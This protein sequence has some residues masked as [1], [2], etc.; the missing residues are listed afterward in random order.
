MEGSTEQAIVPSSHQTNPLPEL[1]SHFSTVL[2]DLSQQVKG[3]M[4][5]LLKMI[6]E[7]DGHSAE[8]TEE[9]ERCRESALERRKAIEEEKDC[10]QKAAFAVLDML[11]TGEGKQDDQMFLGNGTEY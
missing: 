8:V 9:M 2:Y 6:N 5:D 10:F 7:I 4:E 11:N 3:A 1:K